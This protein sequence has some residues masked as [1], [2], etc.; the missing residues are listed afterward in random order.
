MRVAIA[1]F[2]T[3]ISPRFD[4]AQEFLIA[5]TA[6]GEVL[7]KR[8][9]AARSWTPLERIK[10]LTDLEIDTLISGAIDRCSAECLSA[11]CVNTFCCVTGE[12]EDA[13]RCLLKGNLESNMMVGSNGCCCGHWQFR[14]GRKHS[15]ERHHAQNIKR[16]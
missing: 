16:R 6:N 1:L 13:L 11:Q 10:R 8:R 15:S 2:K 5:E 7:E 14:N 3:R 12:A 4:Y 9:I